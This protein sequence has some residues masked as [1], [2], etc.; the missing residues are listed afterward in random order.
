[1]VGGWGLGWVDS[2]GGQ[3]RLAEGRGLL[4]VVTRVQAA[5]APL[6]LH[7]CAACVSACV[8]KQMCFH[9]YACACEHPPLQAMV[10]WVPA[11][12]QNPSGCCP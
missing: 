8:L 7:V 5:V 4:S 3:Q 1:M 6:L 12:A 10:S 11:A 2:Q 9:T